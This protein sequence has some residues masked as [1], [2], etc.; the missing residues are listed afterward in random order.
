MHEDEKK[1]LIVSCD[2]SCGVGAVLADRMAD[3][4]EQPVG[5]A[6]CTLTAAEKNYSLLHEEGLAGRF[7]VL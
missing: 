3:G 4:D 5:F 1:E 7:G 2:A 6:S